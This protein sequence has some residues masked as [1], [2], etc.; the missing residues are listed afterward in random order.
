VQH[1]LAPELVIREL[2]EGGLRATLVEESL[3]DQYVVR[4]TR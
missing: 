2:E 3:P 1:R 4:A